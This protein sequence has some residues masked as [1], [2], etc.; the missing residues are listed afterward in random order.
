MTTKLR[1]RLALAISLAPFNFLR[2]FLYRFLFRYTIRNS[3]IGFGTTIDVESFDVESSHIG[4]FCRFHGPM[5][6]RIASDVRIGRNNTFN[7]GAWT[8][9]AAAAGFGYRREMQIAEKADITSGHYF[10]VAGRLVLGAGSR[11]AGYGSQFWTHGAGVKERD[12]EIGEA[13]FIGS[14]VRFA[15][16]SAVGNRCVIAMGSVVAG[17]FLVDEALIAGVPAA[18]KQQPYNWRPLERMDG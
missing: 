10:D 1:E 15:P 17:R 12:V 14:A 18:I 5:R 3:R 2:V 9:G 11:V 6:V 8:A 13:C 7:C 4:P 16:G